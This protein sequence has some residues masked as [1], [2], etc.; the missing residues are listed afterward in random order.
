V[1]VTKP[2]VA[3]VLAAGRGERM[4]P[5]SAVVP[6]PALPLP[7]APVVWSAI[8]LAATAG[9]SR[10]V[11][12]VW[13]LADRMI[14]AVES[15]DRGF[16]EVVVSREHEL[17]GTSGGLAIARERGLLESKGP[18][19][20]VNGDGLYDLDPE[21]LIERHA[22]SGDEITLGLAPHPDPSRWSRVLVGDDHV[23]TGIVGPDQPGTSDDALLYPGLMLV[24]R[25]LIDKL[26]PSPGNTPE[27]LWWPAME[28]RTLGGVELAG[29]WREVGTPTDYLDEV[30]RQLDRTTV[31]HPT[32]RVDPS[33]RLDACLIGRGAEIGAGAEVSEAAILEGA[34]VAARARVSRSVLAGAI[35]ISARDRLHGVFMAREG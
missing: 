15:V 20:V 35:R 23:V 33:A 2:E 13:H 27:T 12:N 5:L 8:G 24:A 14:E 7:S 22:T 29:T 32:A 6:K 34:E 1:T 26:P 10:V 30:V 21:P 28:R 18:V 11:V 16:L 4:R 19:L 3:M 9:V 17:M 25:H 31:V